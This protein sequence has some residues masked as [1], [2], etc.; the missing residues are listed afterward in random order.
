MADLGP[1]ERRK[2]LERDLHS[3]K[4]DLA[5]AT[6]MAERARKRV[7][8]LEDALRKVDDRQ[9]EFAPAGTGLGHDAEPWD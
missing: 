5:R 9:L 2:Q 3:A 6:D 1:G 4:Q 7:G 8:H